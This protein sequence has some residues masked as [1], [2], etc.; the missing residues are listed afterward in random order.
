MPTTTFDETLVQLKFVAKTSI[1]PMSRA[2]PMDRTSTILVDKTSNQHA[3]VEN[4]P[5]LT[6]SFQL[7]DICNYVSTRFLKN[8]NKIMAITN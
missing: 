4:P 3:L 6:K 5:F 7:H 8:L 2:K 1:K